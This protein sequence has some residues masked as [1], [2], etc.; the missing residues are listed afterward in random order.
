MTAED[1]PSV[2]RVRTPAT[3]AN[4]GPGFDALGLA[5]ALHDEITARV[6]GGG[7]TGGGVTVRVS[8]EGA[9]DLPTGADHLVVR[10]MFAT[11]DLLGECPPA[12]AL[13]C[14]NRIPQARGLGSSSSAIVGGI[15]LA[16]QLVSDGADRLDDAG[17][18]RLASELEGHPDNV[19]PCLL[20]GFTIAWNQ[21]DGARAVRLDPGAG[22]SPVVFVPGE[23]GLTS[24]ARAALPAV[25]P[26]VDAAM[27]VGRA[28]LL[29]HA[30][31][32][33][34]A[35]LLAA[36]E[37]RI[38]QGYRAVAMP[39]TADLVTR[40]RD[41]GVPAVVSGAGPSVLALGEFGWVPPR[42]EGWIVLRLPID[43]TGAGIVGAAGIVEHAE[44]DAVAAGPAS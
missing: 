33:A 27:N 17:V 12:L 1:H 26:H 32:S 24:V 40:L 31:T 6:T 3:C 36:T 34:P 37:D 21:D 5:L 43:W 38:H 25:V 20:G 39:E 8:G 22:L 28:A 42:P 2:A 30:I 16:R 29:V 23:R 11:Y 10:A 7:A 13:D 35:Y 19:A 4:L 44:Q 18:L 9:G 15:L 41:D 14:V